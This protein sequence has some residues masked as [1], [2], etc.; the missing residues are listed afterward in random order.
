MTAFSSQELSSVT[1]SMNVY[2]CLC[3]GQHLLMG[4]LFLEHGPWHARV[5]KVM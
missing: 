1:Y 4:L 2:A 3:I 5:V